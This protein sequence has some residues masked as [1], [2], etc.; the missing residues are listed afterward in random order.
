[1]K[2]AGLRIY[3]DLGSFERS[4]DGSWGFRGVIARGE[5][6]IRRRSK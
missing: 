6:G 3:G 5:V 1:V 2:L 4:S